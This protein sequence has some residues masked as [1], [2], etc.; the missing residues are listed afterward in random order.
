[1][2][3]HVP[4]AHTYR[5]RNLF[6]RFFLLLVYGLIACPAAVQQEPPALRVQRRDVAVASL[7]R[8]PAGK[9]LRPDVAHQVVGPQVRE[10]AAASR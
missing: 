7:G 10:V 2:L 9:E 4:L 5:V 6:R 1:M 8:R 3:P